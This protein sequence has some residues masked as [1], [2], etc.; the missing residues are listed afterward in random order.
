MISVTTNNI[1]VVIYMDQTPYKKVIAFMCQGKN[2]YEYDEDFEM[3]IHPV[4]NA[5]TK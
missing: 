2:G 1:L 4:L 3:E 5:H